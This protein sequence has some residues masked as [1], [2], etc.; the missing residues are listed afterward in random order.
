MTTAVKS[1]AQSI[2]FV[3]AASLITLSWAACSTQARG[4]DDTVV[5][6]QKEVDVRKVSYGDLNLNTEAGAEV[7][8][9]RLRSAADQVCMSSGSLDAGI[10]AAW[11]ACY[12]KAMNS[13]VASVNKPMLTAL[14]NRLSGI[15]TAHTSS[16]TAELA[17]K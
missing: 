14:H 12:D 13:A 16:P 15:S 3:I 10:R 11:R 8:Y 5:D 17:A 9:R 7:L 2:I 6:V 1:H 4:A